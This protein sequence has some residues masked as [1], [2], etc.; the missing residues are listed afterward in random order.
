MYHRQDR[1]PKLIYSQ[2]F[3][4]P[5]IVWGGGLSE[6]S[7]SELRLIYHAPVPRSPEPIVALASISGGE[8]RPFRAQRGFS[9]EPS[10]QANRCSVG[11]GNLSTLPME[12]GAGRVDKTRTPTP[13][14][15]RG[16]AMGR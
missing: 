11:S 6:S 9:P 12:R 3:P 5:S 14:G 8:P 16:E 7:L 10:R 2:C 15:E 13:Y 1:L 4:P